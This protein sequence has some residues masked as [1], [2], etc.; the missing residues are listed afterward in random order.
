MTSKSKFFLSGI[1]CL[2]LSVRV[3]AQVGIGNSQLFCL[4]DIKEPSPSANS[5]GKFGDIP[6]N[7]YVGMPSINIPLFT[8]K[9]REISLPISLTY[10]SSGIKVDEYSGPVG[11]GWALDI[12]GVIT[13]TAIGLRDEY[14]GAGYFASRANGLLPDP[15][16]LWNPTFTFDQQYM[17]ASGTID[18]QPDIFSFNFAGHSGQIVFDVVRYGTRDSLIPYVYPCQDLFFKNIKIYCNQIHYWEIVA[19][20]GTTYCFGD[21][22]IDVNHNDYKA[23]EYT[24]YDYGPC[25]SIDPGCI[26]SWYISSIIS[27]SKGDTIHFIYDKRDH[28]ISYEKTYSQTKS[29]LIAFTPG[30]SQCGGCQ[31]FVQ[32]PCPTTQEVSYSRLYSI[33]TANANIFFEYEG[34]IDVHGASTFSKIKIVTKATNDSIRTF[35]FYTNLTGTNYDVRVWLDS[36]AESMSNVRKVHRFTYYNREELPDRAIEI[37][38]NGGNSQDHWGYYNG[39]YNPTLIPAMYFGNLYYTGA[40]READTSKVTYGTL[41]RIDYP[42]GGYTRFDYESNDYCLSE[43]TTRVVL[44][45][46]PMSARV[47]TYSGQTH[48]DIFIDHDTTVNLAISYGNYQGEETDAGITILDM[49]G[50]IVFAHSSTTENI[51]VPLSAGSYE[52]W[53]EAYYPNHAGVHATWANYDTIILNHDTGVIYYGGGARIKNIITDDGVKQSVKRYIYRQKNRPNLSSGKLL[54]KLPSYTYISTQGIQCFNDLGQ[55]SNIYSCQYFNRTTYSK[56][57]QGTTQGNHVAYRTVTELDGANGENGKIVHDYYFCPDVGGDYFPYPPKT[58]LEWVRGGEIETNVYNDQNELQRTQYTYDS[59]NITLNEPYARRFKAIGGI[60]IGFTFALNFGQQETFDKFAIAPYQVYTG[61]KFPYR[62][63]TKTY[64]KDGLNPV[65]ESTEY[66]YDNPK[67]LQLSRSQ[68]TSSEGKIEERMFKYPEDYPGTPETM[69]STVKAI[70]MMRDSLHIHNQVIEELT[71]ISDPGSATNNV[72]TGS[73]NF[74]KKYS[75]FQVLP[76]KRVSLELNEPLAKTSFTASSIATGTLTFDSHYTK[77][78]I[79]VDKYDKFGN[80]LQYHDNTLMPVSLNYGYNASLVITKAINARYDPSNAYSG[81]KTLVTRYL[82]QPQIGV[83]QITGP[84][85]VTKSYSYDPL[86][87]LSLIRN[88]DNYILQKIEYHL[89]TGNNK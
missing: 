27:P 46:E 60:K 66:Y 24:S 39:K 47:F 50:L 55:L 72:L 11:L 2:A 9:S 56:M 15:P 1:L 69:D 82:H 63:V 14:N 48:E 57:A 58:S 18:L 42:T 51:E 52:L 19:E 7:G 62:S 31:N 29:E 73:L 61:W 68:H 33:E 38:S 67:H 6:V 74:F 86:G 79:T 65:V 76:F 78:N 3:L 32:G 45:A 83:T 35:Q 30:V 26:S 41:K 64:D 87:R 71:L 37:N 53:A 80:I 44:L 16:A 36:V 88:D 20:D 13:R 25:G 34:A 4:Q 81:A 23:T 40:D 12:T 22:D 84:N 5:L 28:I 70:A 8:I 75:R 59:A 43:A 49:N 21:P 85:G 54:G 17:I 89:A 77:Q 10:H